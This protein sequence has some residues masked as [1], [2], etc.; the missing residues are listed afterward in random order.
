VDVV[1]AP[2]Q[3]TVLEFDLAKA[4]LPTEGRADIGIGAD[5]VKRSGR[6]LQVTMHSLGAQDAPA[7]SVMVEDASGK[8]VARAAT[9]PLK[10]PK[11]LKPKTATVK[12]SL[13]DGFDPKG[14]RVRIS[15]PDGTREITQL[16]NTVALP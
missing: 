8:I 10:A 7:G 5:D 6:S 15:L 4:G 3:T 12:L 13:P 2:R 14:A 11:D 16:N 1:F 9:P